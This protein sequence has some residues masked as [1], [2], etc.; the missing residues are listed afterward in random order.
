MLVYATSECDSFLNMHYLGES[1]VSSTI[2]HQR[3]TILLES[4]CH[5][6]PDVQ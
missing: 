1:R 3:G 4:L 6:V 5:V 2:D